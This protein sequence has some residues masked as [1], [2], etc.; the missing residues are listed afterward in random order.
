M[1]WDHKELDMTEQLNW[2]ELNW[3]SIILDILKKLDV[4]HTSQHMFQRGEKTCNQIN[5]KQNGMFW[6]RRQNL[7]S[8]YVRLFAT[9]WTVACQAPLPMK[10][11]RQEYWSGLPFPPPRDLPDPGVKPTSLVSLALAGRFLTTVKWFTKNKLI[12]Y[13]YELELHLQ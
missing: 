5:I 1:Y 11:F 13:G 2:T 9:P 3:L 8:V 6:N 4:I 7:A 12:I 10:F